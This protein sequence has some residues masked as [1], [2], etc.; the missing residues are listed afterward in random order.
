MKKP[1]MIDLD[2][3]PEDDVESA[4]QD[5]EEGDSET[6]KSGPYSATGDHAVD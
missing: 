6:K 3:L 1:D 2:K 5:L 4:E